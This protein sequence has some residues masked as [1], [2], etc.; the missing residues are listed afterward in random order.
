MIWPFVFADSGT[1]KLLS[2]NV[3]P[4]TPRCIPE[5]A[6][7]LNKIVGRTN[8]NLEHVPPTHRVMQVWGMTDRVCGRPSSS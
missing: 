3:R 7:T 8:V 4:E 2:V 1:A 6:P 5:W